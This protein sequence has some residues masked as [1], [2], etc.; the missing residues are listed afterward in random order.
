MEDEDKFNKEIDKACEELE[1]FIFKKQYSSDVV[2]N[3]IVKLVS[4]QIINQEDHILAKMEFYSHIEQCLYGC[5]LIVF[6]EIVE[7]AKGKK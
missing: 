1:E 5:Q 7:E 3:A 2:L 6:K 4:H